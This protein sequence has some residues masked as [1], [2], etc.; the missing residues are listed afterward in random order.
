MK[1]FLTTLF[2]TIFLLVLLSLLPN[3]FVRAQK[4]EAVSSSDNFGFMPGSDR[5]L[6]DYEQLISYFK[7]LDDYSPRLEMREI[8]KSPMGKPMYI[9]FISSEKNIKN[10]DELGEINKKL[11]LDPDLKADQIDALTKKGKVFF[12]ATLS[13]HSS[14]VGPTQSSPLI[15][16]DLATTNDPVKLKW[17]DDVVYMMVPNH[18]P[19]GMDMIVE[20]YRKYK[21]TKYED[22]DMPGVYHKYV[23]HDNN[24]DFI[25][26]SQ[27][28]TKAISEITSKTWFPQVMVEKHQM[29]GSSVRYFVPPNHDPIAQNI[30]EGLWNWNGIF[31]S[32]MIKDLTKEGCSGVAQRY[33]FDNY[34][35][36]STETCLW[37]N[38]AAFLTEAASCSV[39]TPVYIE[40]TELSASG[41]GLSEYKKSSNMPL[42]W[43]GGWWHLSDIVKLELVSTNSIINTC[44]V[45]KEEIL[46]F[47]NELCKKEVE[48]GKTEAPYYY[49]L[50]VEQHDKSEWIDLARLLTEHGINVYKLDNKLVISEK[51]YEAGAFVVPLSQAFRPFIKE[52]MEVQE[53]PVRHYSAAGDLIKPY[54]IATWSLPLHKGVSCDEIK[55]RV[56]ELEKNLQLWTPEKE[57]SQTVPVN[58]AMAIFDVNSNAS[59]KTAFKAS[60]AGLKV[61]RLDEDVTI[62]NNQLKKGSF[63]ISADSKTLNEIMKTSNGSVVFVKDAK[64]YKLADLTVPRIALVE[65]WFHDMD[66]G[67]TRFVLDSYGIPFKVLH[68]GDF[69][70][71]G[72]E[73]D[74]DVLVFPGEDPDVLMKGKVKTAEG[75]YSTTTYPPEFTKGIGEKGFEKILKFLENGGKILSWGESTGLF[76]VPLK[77]KFA[78]DSLEEFSLPVQ[79]ISKSLAAKG[80]YCPGSLVNIK[81][82]KDHPLTMGLE[83]TIGVFYRGKPVFKTSEPYFDMDRRVIATFPEKDILK[84]GYIEKEELL[85]SKTAM[86]WMKKGKGQMILFAFG[87][88]FRAS[89]PVS[90]KLL[91]NALLLPG[92]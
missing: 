44:S 60:M 24:R 56:A 77:I 50:P 67:W 4:Q 11:A 47:R 64:Q 14:E 90:Y 19:D 36:G 3:Q 75:V 20:H 79:D 29:G 84:S 6:F 7:K 72:L 58:T 70:K 16:F 1:A 78:E 21:G 85:D 38:V 27:S 9:L 55:I 40:P 22:S 30:D 31:G 5:N 51:V 37:K 59:F 81:L 25:I 12:L 86:V 49:I 69:E 2:R 87:P 54:D 71:A 41:K 92:L 28:D 62:E 76:T 80:L 61:Q 34:W 39:A 53:Y 8:G 26:L 13:M 65:S 32:N 63:L 23:G 57:V 74:F 66:A 73:K 83:E 82:K 17:L 88:Q 91:F 68:P 35:P 42:P 15:A 43:P 10:L 46:K 52:V 89:T 33:A 18:N 45:N 48:K